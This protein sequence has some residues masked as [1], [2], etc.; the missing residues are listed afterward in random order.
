MNNP[1]YRQFQ[2]SQDP[3]VRYRWRSQDFADFGDNGLF[4]LI[5]GLQE[6]Q[7][8]GAVLKG[9]NLLSCTGLNFTV[10]SGFAVGPTGDLFY[11]PTSVTGTFPQPTAGPWGARSLCVVR[12]LLYT[13]PSGYINPPTVP[14]TTKPLFVDH[15]AQ[16]VVLDGQGA[17]GAPPATGANDVILFGLRLVQNATGFTPSGA[18]FIDRDYP[19]R[20]N[21]FKGGHLLTTAVA[22]DPRCQPYAAGAASVGIRP[23]QTLRGGLLYPG[24]VGVNTGSIFP[25]SGGSYNGDAG[26]TFLNFTTG[27]VSGADTTSSAFSPTVPAENTFIWALVTLTS[28]DLLSVS[29]GTAGTYLQCLQKYKNQSSSGAGGIPTSS[30]FKVALVLLGSNSGSAVTELDVYDVRGLNQNASAAV[31]LLNTRRVTQADSPVT[32]LSTDDVI[33]FDT[34]SGVIAVTM[35][36]R[37]SNQGKRYEFQKVTNDSTVVTMNRAGADTFIGGGT[38]Y[39]LDS[40]YQAQVIIAGTT[41]WL[42]DNEGD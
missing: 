17:S 8:S 18:E 7:F 42:A 33:E 13:P 16:V 36:D 21:S 23:A 37:A 28:A 2:F 39:L 5:Q 25:K 31:P 6:G 10:A 24:Y 9:M 30:N 1:F 11:L 26:D 12:P 4:A 22:W 27:A 40:P 19:G 38:T 15:Y 3:L 34:S 32:V 29:Y 35:P 41:S 14:L 20:R